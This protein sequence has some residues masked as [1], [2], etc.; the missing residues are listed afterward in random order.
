MSDLTHLCADSAFPG[1]LAPAPG[2]AVQGYLSGPTPHVWT[3]QEWDMFG[4]RP[5]YPV[6]VASLAVGDHGAAVAE[7]FAALEQAYRI[8]QPKG[9]VIG[10]DMETAIA[11]FLAGELDPPAKLGQGPLGSDR[12][13]ADLARA[14]HPGYLTRV[15]AVLQASGYHMW[16]YGSRSTVFQC[17]PCDGYDVADW[18]GQPHFTGHENERACQFAN[19][20]QTG[21]NFD[22]RVIK[23]WSWNHRLWR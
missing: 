19:S 2:W 14:A 4:R 5:K 9:T 13:I 20:E 3:P 23:E 6:A 15:H 16:V 7:A 21:G 22:A 8:G 10:W 12:L 17:P 11:R 18:T 1:A